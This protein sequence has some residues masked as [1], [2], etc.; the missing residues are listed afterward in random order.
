[1]FEFEI[2][3]SE[4]KPR[5]LEEI[6]NI[7]SNRTLLVLKLT[8]ND[9]VSPKTLYGLNTVED[10]L[11]HFRPQVEVEMESPEGMPTK[12]TIRFR[13]IADFRVKE[14]VAQ[15]PFLQSL[16]T[17]YQEYTQVGRRLK[18]HALLRTMLSHAETK[19]ALLNTL[20]AAADQITKTGKSG[21]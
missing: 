5:A 10:V 14:L 21:Q 18:G 19:A 1:M 20:R 17:Q 11:N 2:G 12:E 4:T 6:S 16:D 7:P 8:Q 9:P 3:G 13:R 15:S